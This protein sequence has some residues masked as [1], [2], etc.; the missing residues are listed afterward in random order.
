MAHKTE[1]AKKNKFPFG[2]YYEDNP[3]VPKWL[4]DSKHVVITNT[5]MH[6]YRINEVGISKSPVTIKHL[7]DRLWSN[8]EIYNF[9]KEKKYRKLTD[10]FAHILVKEF[11]L[12]YK[13]AKRLNINYSNKIKHQAREWWN[14][15]KTETEFSKR[16]KIKIKIV[17]H[18]LFYRLYTIYTFSKSKFDSLKRKLK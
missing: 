8:N 2:R 3:T 1:I 17:T 13:E 7:E 6:F 14:R 5:K 10:K 4:Y 9:W 16:E 15:N 18:S 12:C 11:F